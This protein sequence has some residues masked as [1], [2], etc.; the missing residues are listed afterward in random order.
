MHEPTPFVEFL[1]FLIVATLVG[2]PVAVA[3]CLW[4]AFFGKIHDDD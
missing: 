2:G 3:W 4:K 1:A